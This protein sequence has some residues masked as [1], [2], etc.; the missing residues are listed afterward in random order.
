MSIVTDCAQ[1]RHNHI[2]QGNSLEIWYAI[3]MVFS[4]TG[5]RCFAKASRNVVVGRV[6]ATLD[7]NA[8]I[9]A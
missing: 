9:M 5:D 6:R 1:T 8:T 3:I 2:L 7:Y 4:I